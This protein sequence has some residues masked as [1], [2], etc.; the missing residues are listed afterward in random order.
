MSPKINPKALFY[1]IG[2]AIAAILLASGIA[3]IPFYAPQPLDNLA[4]NASLFEFGSFHPELV[5]GAF[6]ILYFIAIIALFFSKEGR[7]RLLIF[8]MVLACVIFAL[9]TYAPKGLQPMPET[10][11]PQAQPTDSAPVTTEQPELLPAPAIAI[12]ETPAWL[13][14]L[15]ELTVAL[16]IAAA[17]MAIVWL[18]LRYRQDAAVTETLA[19]EAQAAIDAL[20]AGDD[21]KDVVTRCYAQMS[22]ALLKERGLERSKSMTPQ[23]FERLLVKIGFPAEP[24]HTLTHLFEEVRYGSIPTSEPAIQKAI[25]SLNAILDHCKALNA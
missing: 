6:F 22:Q 13:I 18:A 1:F 25:A 17:I 19:Q 9:Y 5:V 20:E 3:R 2:A 11:A 21:F 10:I 8:L 4:N 14:T 15:V 24:I 23:E 12:P 16:L 7:R